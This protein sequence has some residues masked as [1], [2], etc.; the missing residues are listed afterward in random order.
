MTKKFNITNQNY[1]RRKVNDT[2]FD[3]F[4]MHQ[5]P[6]QQRY[7]GNKCANCGNPLRALRTKFVFE[8]ANG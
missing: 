2:Y 6:A 5:S 4:L 7:W 8:D 1:K 3:N